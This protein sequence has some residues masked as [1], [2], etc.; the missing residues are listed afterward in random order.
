MILFAGGYKMICKVCNKKIGFWELSI[1]KMC[2]S[3]Y[4]KFKSAQRVQEKSEMPKRESK[5]DEK[6]IEKDEVAGNS[7]SISANLLKVLGLILSALSF[8]TVII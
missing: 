7:Y 5:Q 2:M 8:V 6:Q 4:R 1:D 3:C